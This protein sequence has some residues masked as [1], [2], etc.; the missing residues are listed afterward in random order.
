MREDFNP[1]KDKLIPSSKFYHQII[2]PVYIPNF[3]GYFKDSFKILDLSLTSLF[4]TVHDATFI[5]IVNNGSCKIVRLFLEN[6][7][8]EKKIHEL[9]HTTNIG[10]INAMLKGTTGQEFLFVTTSDADVLYLNNWQEET[11]KIFNNFASAGA[12]SPV[13]NSKVLKY[14]TEN[15]FLAKGFSKKMRFIKNENPKAMKKFALSIGNKDLFNN[16]HLT[17]CLALTENNSFSLVGA[18]HFIITYRKELINSIKVRNTK[19][20]M[21]GD[22]DFIFDKQVLDSGFWRLSTINNFALHMGNIEENWMKDTVG[23]IEV[24]NKHFTQPVLKA[25]VQR[26]RNILLKKLISGI[27]FKKPFWNLFLRLKGLSRVEAKHY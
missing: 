14:F 19:F 13:P 8:E 25:I 11:Y 24:V 21:G 7:F 20:L 15:I 16:I 6:L 26:K 17:K 23:K 9:I 27:L 1:Q 12:V 3:E 5:T 2:I 4:K 18:S 22:S 10:Y